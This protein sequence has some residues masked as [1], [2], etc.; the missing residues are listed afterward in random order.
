MRKKKYLEIKKFHTWSLQSLLLVVGL[1][2]VLNLISNKNFLFERLSLIK[3]TPTPVFQKVTIQPTPAQTPTPTST[4][5]LTPYP[6]N[7]PIVNQMPTNRSIIAA[8]KTYIYSN[9]QND[10]NYKNKKKE[11]IILGWAIYFDSNPIALAQAE[12]NIQTYESVRQGILSR[13]FLNLYP[14][15]IT[16]TP[17]GL[18]T[19]QICTSW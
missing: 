3:P 19:G 18:L 15:S 7:S 5:T 1:L 14:H 4:P 6:T 8:T 12:T 17:G 11:E 9:V 16:C 2:L 10:P 13:P